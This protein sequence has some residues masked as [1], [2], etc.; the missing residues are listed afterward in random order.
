VQGVTIL[1]GLSVL[2]GPVCASTMPH[3]LRGSADTAAR[4]GDFDGDGRRDALY[5]VN[6][7]ATGRI[8]VH[9]RLNTEAGQHDIRVSSYD[10]NSGAS[11]PRVVPAGRYAPDCGSFATDCGQADIVTRSDSLALDLGDGVTVLMH[12]QGDRF[13]Q[14]FIKPDVAAPWAGL[15]DTMAGVFAAGR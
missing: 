6:D 4:E 3:S 13:D 1:A 7:P 12:W 10:A 2:A 8:A 9:V 15:A 14:D 11:L 5:L